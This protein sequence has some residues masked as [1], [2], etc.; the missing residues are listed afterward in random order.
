[1]I[2]I[3]WKENKTE[4]ENTDGTELKFQRI[5]GPTKINRNKTRKG[6]QGAS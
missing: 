6:P 5:D 3:T 1:M 4:N 2:S